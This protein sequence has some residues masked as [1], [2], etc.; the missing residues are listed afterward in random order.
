METAL[1]SGRSLHWPHPGDHGRIGSGPSGS[2]LAPCPGAWEQGCWEEEAR[3]LPCAGPGPG[4]GPVAV[5]QKSRLPSCPMFQKALLSPGCPHSGTFSHLDDS[6]G[7]I[8]Y[9]RVSQQL[10]MTG[11]WGT[12]PWPDRALLRWLRPQLNTNKPFAGGHK[13]G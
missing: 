7:L 8:Q 12:S 13:T 1:A 10:T 9:R 3:L 5:S 6:S 2:P 11:T 4:P